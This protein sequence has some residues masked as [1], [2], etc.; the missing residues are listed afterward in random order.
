MKVSW[1]QPVDD[2]GTPIT[3]YLIEYKI[4]TSTEWVLVNAT[5]S[6]D[7]TIVVKGLEENSEYIFRVYAENEVGLSDASLPSDV[8]RTLGRSFM[9]NTISTNIKFVLFRAVFCL[10]L[11]VMFLVLFEY[12]VLFLNEIF[13]M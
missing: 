12:F 11:F 8:Q 6:T 2:G 10:F 13:I 9:Y 1:T 7:T 5:K 3:G 4:V